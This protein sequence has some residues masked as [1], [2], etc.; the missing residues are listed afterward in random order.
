[1][2]LGPTDYERALAAAGLDD[3]TVFH[4]QI[5]GSTNDDAREIVAKHLPSLESGVAI[6]V[7][8]AQTSGRGRGSNVWFSP[9]DSIALTIT[10]P[11]LQ[12]SRLSVL[13]LGV[14]AAVAGALRHLGAP[15]DVKWPN[16]V[17]IGGL[18]VCGILCESS[19]LSG[20]A[21]VFV[22][23]GINVESAPV[24]PQVAPN[25]AALSAFGIEVDR[26]S[27][28]ADITARVLGVVR[29]GDSGPQIVEA[30]KAL[31]VPCWGEEASIVEGDLEKRVT[32]LDVSP[33]GHLIVRDEEGGVR[34][35]VSG[36][37]RQLRTTRA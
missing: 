31:S 9:R 4:R 33:E 24:D 11:G 1:M 3:V 17:L 18:K 23:I 12:V 7:A 8:E 20:R 35:L 22:G 29:G 16:D 36:E 25:A 6:V 30:W 15:A 5:T 37:V 13:P 19:L 28:V 26:P 2:S 32:L 27:L 14:G 34:S 10:A 21:R